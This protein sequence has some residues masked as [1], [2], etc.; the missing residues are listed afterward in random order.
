MWKGTEISGAHKLRIFKNGDPGKGESITEK[1]VDMMNHKPK[2]KP[3]T[4][5]R[6]LADKM[7]LL[8]KALQTK[9]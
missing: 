4:V 9:A 1:V 6:A 5:I 3:E 8:F 2:G 7:S